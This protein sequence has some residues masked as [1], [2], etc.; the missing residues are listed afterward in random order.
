MMRMCPKCFTAEDVSPAGHGQYCCENPRHDDGSYTWTPEPQA[1]PATP[2]RES[3]LI[4]L[5]VYDDLLACIHGDDGWLEWGVVEDRY[6][7]IAPAT[8]NDLVQRYSHSRRNAVRGGPDVKPA[9]GRLV[10][11]RLSIALG[12]L[13]AE[14][15]V[16]WSHRQATGYWHYNGKTSF[17]APVPAPAEDNVLTWESYATKQ[18]LDPN[19][20]VLSEAK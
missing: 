7:N 15:L 19:D 18:G 17:Y 8:Y 20:W 11:N 6:R 2:G 4:E 1:K 10:S 9:H 16:S 12:Q 5:G 3:T 14:G 13:H